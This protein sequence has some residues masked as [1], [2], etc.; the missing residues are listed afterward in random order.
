MTIASASSGEKVSGSDG[1][2]GAFCDG[3]SGAASSSEAAGSSPEGLSA[4][5]AADETGESPAGSG[6]RQTSPWARHRYPRARAW[7]QANASN[8]DMPAPARQGA[9]ASPRASA[10]GRTGGFSGDSYNPSRFPV[11][12]KTQEKNGRIRRFFNFFDKEALNFPCKSYIIGPTIEWMRRYAAW[13]RFWRSYPARG[14]TGKTSV[15]AGVAGCLCLE[16]ARVL[17][18]DAGPRASQ[19]RHFARHGVGGVGF[20]SGSDAGRLHARAGAA[21]GRAFRLQLLTAPVSVC[22]ED[23]DEAQFAC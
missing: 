21:C 11:Y 9:R 12:A 23:L 13:G 16:G 22:A 17:C 15:C 7:A 8:R 19:S 2:A 6:V 14:G 3:S 18:I 20:V 10:R 1:S 5:G 4:S